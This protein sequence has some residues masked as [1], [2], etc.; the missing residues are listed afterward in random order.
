MVNFHGYVRGV[1]ILIWSSF[2][3]LPV[4]YV[5]QNPGTYAQIS[6]VCV[7]DIWCVF[8]YS[9]MGKLHFSSLNLARF[10]LLVIKLKK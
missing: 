9:Y 8:L 5:Q 3:H 1:C 7:G 6:W 4:V 2:T 10:A